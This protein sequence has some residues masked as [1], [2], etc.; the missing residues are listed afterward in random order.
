MTD[1]RKAA[2][3]DTNVQVLTPFFKMQLQARLAFDDF[4]ADAKVACV[5]AAEEYL[6]EK[7]DVPSVS[8]ISRETGLP[9]QIVGDILK[10]RKKEQQPFRRGRAH[11]ERVLSGWWSDPAYLDLDGR[12]LHLPASGPAPS[13]ESLAVFYQVEQ[14]QPILEELIRTK[15]V[16][17]T[18]NE[19]YE[20]VRRTCVDI[21]WDPDRIGDVGLQVGTHLD[22]MLDNINNPENEPHVTRFYQSR[23]IDAL[24][25]RILH[26]ELR[27]DA[28]RFVDS[29]RDRVSRKIYAAKPGD[30]NGPARQFSIAV[31]IVE[32][33]LEPPPEISE[34]SRPKR[35][36]AAS[37]SSLS[38]RA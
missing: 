34:P 30:T 3:S 4:V 25:A 21:K 33:T 12:P 18:A 28:R 11:A 6:K 27:L 14:P 22:A 10:A 29:A 24:Q 1:R 17:K 16:R 36:T 38:T 32:R 9:R 7:G 2:V 20:P 35:R 13:F 31:Q 19:C 37:K 15:A 8:R 26:R 23:E 5:R